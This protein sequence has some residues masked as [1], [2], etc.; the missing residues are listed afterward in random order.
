MILA[1]DTTIDIRAQLL[2]SR[3]VFKHYDIRFCIQSNKQLLNGFSALSIHPS[4][5]CHRLLELHLE[6]P[7]VT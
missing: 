7:D 2:V 4:L 5:L 3:M 1:T 6:V